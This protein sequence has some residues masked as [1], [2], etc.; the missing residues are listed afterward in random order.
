[1]NAKANR[2]SMPRSVSPSQVSAPAGALEMVARAAAEKGQCAPGGTAETPAEGNRSRP[3]VG[4]NGHPSRRLGFASSPGQPIPGVVGT[5][6]GCS[7]AELSVVERLV[8]GSQVAHLS[9][10]RLATGGQGLLVDAS[11]LAL[12]DRALP[13]ARWLVQIPAGDRAD[14]GHRLGP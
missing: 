2:S 7:A 14:G 3:A 10:R 4:N 13:E 8:L 12:P 1:M 9:R 11:V 5:K 6:R